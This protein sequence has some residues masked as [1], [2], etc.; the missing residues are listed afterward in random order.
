MC[1]EMEG[2][3]RMWTKKW[4]R[5]DSN[6]IPVSIAA[7]INHECELPTVPQFSQGHYFWHL[8]ENKEIK[9]NEKIVCSLQK[10]WKTKKSHK[11]WTTEMRND[12]HT[13]LLTAHLNM[14]VWE[15]QLC[16]TSHLIW[17]STLCANTL[18]CTQ[19]HTYEHLFSVWSFKAGG[20][21]LI[22]SVD[23]LPE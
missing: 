11:H 15:D 1:W 12:H 5:P 19:I 10:Q 2:Q 21:K 3:T 16:H 14:W 8:W 9:K 20:C 13:L 18:T 23:L 6:S 4:C 17:I 7:L 22:L